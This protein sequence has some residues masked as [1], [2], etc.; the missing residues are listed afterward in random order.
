[1]DFKEQMLNVDKG[2]KKSTQIYQSPGSK[3]QQIALEL[4]RAWNPLL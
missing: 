3:C 1:M 4:R 2:K